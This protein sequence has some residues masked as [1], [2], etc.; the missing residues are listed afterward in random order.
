VTLKEFKHPFV[1]FPGEKGHTFPVAF[2][3]ASTAKPT[4]KPHMHASHPL[5]FDPTPGMK[6]RPN[7]YK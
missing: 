7:R 2:S 5:S 4:K 3:A 1:G 6:G